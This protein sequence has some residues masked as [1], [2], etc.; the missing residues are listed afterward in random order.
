MKKFQVE[1]N[2]IN[3]LQKF[4]YNRVDKKFME[5]YFL[6][7]F[8]DVDTEDLWNEFRKNQIAFITDNQ[9]VGFFNHIKEQILAR[10]YKG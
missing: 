10:N 5:D 7:E 8:R 3:I 4:L 2:D 6:T 9:E 1:F